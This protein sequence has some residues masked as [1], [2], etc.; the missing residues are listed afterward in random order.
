MDGFRDHSNF[1]R[2]HIGIEGRTPAEAAGI[3]W[4]WAGIG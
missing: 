2:P 3:D 4:S 1:L